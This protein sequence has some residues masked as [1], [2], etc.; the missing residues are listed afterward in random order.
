[1]SRSE[2]PE[3]KEEDDRAKGQVGGGSDGHPPMRSMSREDS[4]ASTATAAATDD[5]YNR[6]VNGARILLA[7]HVLGLFWE[8]LLWDKNKRMDSIQVKYLSRT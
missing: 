6:N 5:D 7:Y 3:E 8:H 4:C 1:M 2:A